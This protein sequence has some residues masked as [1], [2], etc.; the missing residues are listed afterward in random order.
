VLL[1]VLET[2]IWDEIWGE[3]KLGVEPAAILQIMDELDLQDDDSQLLATA[4]L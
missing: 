1:E 2:S 3:T 4:A